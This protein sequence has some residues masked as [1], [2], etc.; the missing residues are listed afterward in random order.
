MAVAVGSE[1]LNY[2]RLTIGFPERGK[3]F[4]NKKKSVNAVQQE[5]DGPS[6]QQS[7]G[8]LVTKE[9]ESSSMEKTRALGAGAVGAVAVGAFA[10]G[11]LAMGAVAVATLFVKRAYFGEVEVD[12]LHVHKLRVDDAED[13]DKS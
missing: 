10:L 2:L 13:S 12:T 6:A 3:M 5:I 4:G 11:A 8:E 9:R 7:K 1:C